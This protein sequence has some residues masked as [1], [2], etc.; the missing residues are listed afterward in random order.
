MGVLGAGAEPG[1]PTQGLRGP[2][3]RGACLRPRAPPGGPEPV[4]P[5]GM[6][7]QVPGPAGGDL[8]Q[9]DPRQGAEVGPPALPQGKALEV[10]GFMRAG[11]KGG[12]PALCPQAASKAF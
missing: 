10:R 8:G 9:G 11:D 4:L 12:A 5:P 2:G 7:A 1:E 6:R 3:D